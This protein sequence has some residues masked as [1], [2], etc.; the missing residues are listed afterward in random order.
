MEIENMK[1][2]SIIP[3][4][5]GS[6][7]LP[8]KNTIDFLG[9]PLICWTVDSAIKS[10]YIDKTIISTDSQDIADICNKNGLEVP[11]LRPKELAQE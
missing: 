2:L 6:K 1:V 9:K 8:G 7:R 4:R 5:G 10:N 11:Y 3:A